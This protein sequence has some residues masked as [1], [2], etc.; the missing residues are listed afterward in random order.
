MDK[1]RLT[2][3]AA[4]L[5]GKVKEGAGKLTGDSAERVQ[6]GGD[7]LLSGWGNSAGP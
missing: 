1:D 2:G 6:T 3:S 5:G 7:D 4:N